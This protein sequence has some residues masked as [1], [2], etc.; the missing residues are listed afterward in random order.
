[1]VFVPLKLSVGIWKTF[2]KVISLGL[3]SDFTIL[4]THTQTHISILHLGTLVFMHLVPWASLDR[5]ILGHLHVNLAHPHSPPTQAPGAWLCA[6]PMDTLKWKCTH[7]HLHGGALS[8]SSA[9]NVCDHLYFTLHH[10]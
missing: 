6:H 2:I 5:D 9:S 1:M 3:M 10:Q 7:T 8:S 4:H